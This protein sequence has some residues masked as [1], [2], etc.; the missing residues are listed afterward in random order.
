[1]ALSKARRCDQPRGCRALA[2]LEVSDEVSQA[3]PSW[4]QTGA[5]DAEGES[6]AH[7]RSHRSLRG[8]LP[9]YGK[10]PPPV[11][12]DFRVD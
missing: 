9:G 4:G 11:Q 12:R 3:K 7:P 10:S 2:V 5:Q 6:P 1:M 8:V